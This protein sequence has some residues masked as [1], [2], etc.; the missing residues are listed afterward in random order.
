M[1][2]FVCVTSLPIVL[3]IY[4]MFVLLL[5]HRMGSDWN[6]V[7]SQYGSFLSQID[8]V[9]IGTQHSEIPVDGHAEGSRTPVV[10]KSLLKEQS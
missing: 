3:L 1:L 2:Q 8:E 9:P 10:P 7:M 4:V 6:Q 5:F